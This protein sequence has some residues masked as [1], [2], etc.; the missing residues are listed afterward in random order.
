MFLYFLALCHDI[1]E[2]QCFQK[3]RDGAVTADIVP[4][5]WNF[6]RVRPLALVPRNTKQRHMDG[7]MITY[8]K[9]GTILGAT[10]IHTN[11]NDI[12]NYRLK[13][14]YLA[15]PQSYYQE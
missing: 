13:S 8:L 9:G 5:N 14:V 3:R 10:G 1:P 2:M 11:R 12:N 4:Q 7:H 6:C 15:Q